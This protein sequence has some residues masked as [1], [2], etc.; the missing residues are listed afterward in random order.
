MLAF[1]Y[2]FIPTRKFHGKEG[3][4]GSSPSEGFGGSSWRAGFSDS[5]WCA[6]R[7][8][9]AGME[10]IWKPAAWFCS[11]TGAGI[12]PGVCRSPEVSRCSCDPP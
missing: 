10:T 7:Q 2:P 5:G 4:D 9:Q 6:G 3:V 11:L 8:P 1:S 12:G